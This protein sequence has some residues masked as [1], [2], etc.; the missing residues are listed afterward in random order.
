MSKTAVSCGALVYKKDQGKTWI[1]LV[2]QAGN[3]PGWGI[4]KGH[5]EPGESYTATA[6]REVNEETG[7]NI[8]ILTRLPH[9]T[10]K[11]KNFTKT[12]V[13]YLAVQT[14]NSKPRCDHTASEV[15]DVQWF[16]M[17]SLPII[18]DYQKPII[19]AAM[20][21]LGGYING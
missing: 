13:P 8:K 1:L 17:D 11:R 4:P 18:Y 20:L 2:K 9:V 21:I 3:N 12:V 14:C 16:D 6:L 19:D 5:M 10:I 7:I 15:V